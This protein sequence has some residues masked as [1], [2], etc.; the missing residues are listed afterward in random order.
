MILNI[1]GGGGSGKTT[2]QFFLKEKEGFYTFVPLTTRI[3][4]DNELDGMH[5]HFI[6]FEEF[7]RDKSIVMTRNT[8]KNYFYGIRMDDI[9]NY[10]SIT[11]TTL[12]IYGIEELEKL[13]I[14]VKVIYLDISED[15]RTR[16]MRERGD[17]MEQIVDRLEIDRFSFHK[18]NFRY[19]MLKINGGSVESI[20]KK[21]KYWLS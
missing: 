9:L 11:V 13:N 8:G 6:T 1:L 14:L 7:Q 5:Y 19:P 21:I 10:K 3:K 17:S 15:E 20:Y 12:D 2:L 4:R 16:R 18:L